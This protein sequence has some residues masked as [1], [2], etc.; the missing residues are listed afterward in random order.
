MDS[1]GKID[2]SQ[3]ELDELRQAEA[4]IN[5]IQ[6]PENYANLMAAIESRLAESA[7]VEPQQ[8]ALPPSRSEANAENGVL[9]PFEFRS[10]LYKRFLWAVLLV[11]LLGDAISLPAVLADREEIPTFFMILAFAGILLR[12]GLLAVLL[13]KKGPINVLVYT[14]G[15][16]FIVSGS[17]KLL[18][19]IL[20]VDQVPMEAYLDHVLRL[21][22]G[23]L[24]VVPFNNSVVR[25]GN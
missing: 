24:I 5:S 25:S 2:Y 8:A 4:T 3:Y 23:L 15:G 22:I 19:L 16:L 13:L 11:V 1:D 18:A 17:A 6:Y 14:W 7:Q 9:A 12:I 21:V 20:S 10:V